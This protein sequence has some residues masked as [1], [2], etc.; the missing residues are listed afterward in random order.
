MFEDRPSI[1]DPGFISYALRYVIMWTLAIVAVI[2]FSRFLN[3]LLRR[4][5]IFELELPSWLPVYLTITGFVQLSLGMVTYIAL[6]EQRSWRIPALWVTALLTIG[7]A[8]V[9]RLVLWSPDQQ[10][11]NHTFTIALHLI[12]LA[13]IALY[14]IKS[15]REEPIN[16]QGD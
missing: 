12:W 5:I 2:G 7:F 11:A 10:P 1:K 9:E 13:M 4:G 14:T 8:W 6:K 16:G 3:A 15:T